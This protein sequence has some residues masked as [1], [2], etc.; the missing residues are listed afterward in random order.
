MPNSILF[1]ELTKQLTGERR[2]IIHD[3]SVRQPMNCKYLSEL[4]GLVL[5][6]VMLLMMCVSIHLEWASTIMTNIS[7]N[8]RASKVQM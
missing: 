3:N 8:E 5:G 4:L 7:P 6:A 1:H 2:I